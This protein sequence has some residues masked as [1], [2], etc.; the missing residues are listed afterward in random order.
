MLTAVA[1]GVNNNI[2]NQSGRFSLDLDPNSEVGRE[3]A[4]LL[5]VVLWLALVAVSFGLGP[6]LQ[7]SYSWLL[8]A[9][10][11]T[12][13]L[14]PILVPMFLVNKDELIEHCTGMGPLQ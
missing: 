12:L 4:G 10:A 6:G 5:L 13:C 9:V 11:T 8:L 14:A 7:V 2:N 3:N 1:L